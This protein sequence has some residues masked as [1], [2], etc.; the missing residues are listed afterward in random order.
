MSRRRINQ[1]QERRIKSHQDKRAQLG[2]PQDDQNVSG[3][4]TGLVISFY[5]KEALVETENQVYRCNIRQHLGNIVCGDH[6]QWQ[7]TNSL[8]NKGVIIARLPRNTVLSRKDAKGQLSPI[9]ANI[10]QIAIVIATEPKPIQ[11]VLDAYLVASRQVAANAIIIFNKL[12]LVT[13]QANL[14]T[15]QTWLEIYQTLGYPTFSIS[16][17]TGVGLDALQ[18]QFASEV[19]VVV[20]QS[21]VGK[22]SLINTIL[23]QRQDYS[24]ASTHGTHTT[25]TARYYHLEAQGALIDS[26]GVRDFGLWSMPATEIAQGF[27]EF[28]PYLGS[29]KFR[30]CQHNQDQ[31]CALQQ[32][33]AAHAISDIRWQ[34]Y[35]QLVKLYGTN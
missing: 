18:Q 5:G 16:T 14:H 4:Q 1:Q 21:G 3:S 29:C 10:S 26:P 8:Q 13:D 9:A 2:L 32:A 22:S 19:S 11:T 17:K 24:G 6:V 15:Y 25:T 12:D 35:L 23:K 33:L 30:N 20:G 31:G 28:K 27:I 7:L 34:S